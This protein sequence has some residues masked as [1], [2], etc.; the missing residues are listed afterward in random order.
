MGL[1]AVH[2]LKIEAAEYSQNDSIVFV[3]G[4]VF[5]DYNKSNKGINSKK[6]WGKR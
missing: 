5:A 4:I 1:E 6:K 2:S 3:D